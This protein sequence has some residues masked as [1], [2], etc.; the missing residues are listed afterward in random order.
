MNSRTTNEIARKASHYMKQKPKHKSSPMLSDLPDELIR[1]I[2]EAAGSRSA[3]SLRQTGRRMSSVF[4]DK[5]FIVPMLMSNPRLLYQCYELPMTVIYDW[6]FLIA[7]ALTEMRDDPDGAVE[8]L[9]LHIM[10]QTKQTLQNALRS[11]DI[12]AEDRVFVSDLSD[13]IDMILFRLDH[14]GFLD[15]NPRPFGINLPASRFDIFRDCLR[16][17]CWIGRERHSS[18]DVIKEVAQS[19]VSDGNAKDVLEMYIDT[20]FGLMEEFNKA[21]N[22]EA[23]PIRHYKKYV[24]HLMEHVL[25]RKEALDADYRDILRQMMLDVD[26]AVGYHHMTDEE[27]QETDR[28]RKVHQFDKVRKDDFRMARNKRFGNK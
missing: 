21:V 5:P 12:S 9:V 20:F 8:S 2:G 7:R 14:S 23:I 1:S 24:A 16:N 27:K 26:K 18:M 10:Y 13:R 25:L 11:Q 28:T 17:G 15:Q 3:A 19:I 4:A 22:T 6:H